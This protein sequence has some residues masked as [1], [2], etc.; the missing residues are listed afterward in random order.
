MKEGVA[1]GLVPSAAVMAARKCMPVATRLYRMRLG[2]IWQTKVGLSPDAR[3]LL[4]I[5]TFQYMIADNYYVTCF[6]NHLNSGL[7]GNCI[8]RIMQSKTEAHN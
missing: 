2:V 3:S 1:E 6:E 8:S 5:G 4:A 7:I